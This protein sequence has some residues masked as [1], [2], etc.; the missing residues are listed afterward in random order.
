MSLEITKGLWS[1]LDDLSESV[2][3]VD[4]DLRLLFVNRKASE[5]FGISAEDL[6]GMLLLH[7]LPKEEEARWLNAATE[8][9]THKTI[10]RSRIFLPQQNQWLVLHFYPQPAWELIIRC[11][12]EGSAAAG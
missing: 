12:V 8:A 6:K 3:V 7:V 9:M 5:L 11:E 1:F 10:L 2:F 4:G